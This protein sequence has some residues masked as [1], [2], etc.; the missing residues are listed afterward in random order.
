MS[1][2]LQ[3]H[4]SS[5]VLTGKGIPSSSEGSEGDLQIR[6][7]KGGLKLFARY[8]NEWWQ[9][10][11]SASRISGSEGNVPQAFTNLGG[12]TTIDKNTGHLLLGGNIVLAG[13]QATGGIG[14]QAMGDSIKQ[15]GGITSRHMNFTGKY[16]IGLTVD[17]NDDIYLQSSSLRMDQGEAITFD[18]DEDSHT[19]ISEA[20]EDLLRIQVGGDIMLELKEDTQ[21]L[22]KVWNSD[23]Q[24]IG[25][26][27]SSTGNAELQFLTYRNTVPSAGQDGDDLGKI[28]FQGYNDAGTPELTEFG[29]MKGEIEDATD[30][31]EGMKLTMA[32]ASRIDTMNNGNANYVI[33]SNVLTKP[34]F[35]LTNNHDSASSSEMIFKNDRGGNG[36]T[37]NQDGDLIGT[38][39]FEGYNDAG[40]PEL[41]TFGYMQ[42]TV[43]DATDS[44]E[45]GT[46]KIAVLTKDSGGTGSG[47]ENGILIQGSD[48]N[49]EVDV[50]IGNGTASM[51]TIAGDLDIDGDT[52]TTPNTL[53]IDSGDGRVKFYDSG[54]DDDYFFIMTND[55]T[56][57]TTLATVS[58][59]ADGHLT[60]GSDGDMILDSGTGKFIAK[61][62]GTEFSAANSAYAGMVLGY[63]KLRNLGTGS[64]DDTIQIALQL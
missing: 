12:N 36:G 46:M 10:G 2:R 34:L 23:L 4:K 60:V 62:S 15:V 14:M 58:A 1:R 33:E 57:A 27:N 7:T 55:G 44:S 30:G 63:T 37:A 59:G 50:T 6:A 19:S 5:R 17:A 39:S 26:A 48:T 3:H 18:Y 38:I 64:I 31:T 13:M 56:G 22:V 9:M 42:G 32:Y 11:E 21:S 53:I 52:I 24:L 20:S 41:K 35:Y 25:N 51:T 40:T 8:K 45:A 28:S 29:Y 43:L 54:D 16:N 49:D 61:N 47:L